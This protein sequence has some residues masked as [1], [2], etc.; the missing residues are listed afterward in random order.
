MTRKRGTEASLNSFQQEGLVE[1]SMDSSTYVHLVPYS[2]RK[3]SAVKNKIVIELLVMAY[4]WFF[5]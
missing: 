1:C 4:T 2:E 5:R 3:S